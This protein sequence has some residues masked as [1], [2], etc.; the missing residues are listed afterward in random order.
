M[1]QPPSIA[2][3]VD[4]AVG[5][6]L[7][8]HPAGAAAATAGLGS[9]ERAIVE[10]ASLLRRSLSAPAVGPRFEA[11]LAARLAGSLHPRDAVTW[12]LRHP[13]RLIVTGA[14]GSA[15]G[16][17]VTAYAVWR[18]GRRAPSATHRFLHR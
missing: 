9:D 7:D 12:A 8:G 6:V 15:V 18:N 17:G 11:R 2:E 16:V 4:R 13:G 5:E 14:V 3:R 10:V 1:S